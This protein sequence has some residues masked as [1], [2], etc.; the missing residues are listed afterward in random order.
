PSHART[1]IDVVLTPAETTPYIQL[2]DDGRGKALRNLIYEKFDSWL[3][4]LNVGH[5]KLSVGEKRMKTVQYV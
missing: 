2:V 4:G 1:K 5:D 3:E